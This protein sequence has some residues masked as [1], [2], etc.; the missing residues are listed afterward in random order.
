M[1]SD[2]LMEWYHNLRRPRPML[3]IISGPSGVGKDATLDAMKQM[4][5]PF[6]FV[7]T[8]TTRPRREY[9]TDGVDYHFISMTDFATMID[10]DELLEYAMV[11]GDY[12]GIPKKHVRDALASGRDVVMRIDVQGAATIRRLVAGAI[13][14]FMT[15][16][17]EE[18]LV[19]RL[20]RRK[21]ESEDQLRLRIATARKELQRVNEFDYVVVNQEDHLADTA[22][23]IMAIIAAEKCRVHWKPVEL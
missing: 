10:N 5:T 1:V 15:A 2:E 9:E 20:Q 17:S 12:K 11:Y 19:M 14:V 8:A 3:I 18:E 6:Y 7:V 22:R 13:T 21:T 23:Q 16:P 4:G